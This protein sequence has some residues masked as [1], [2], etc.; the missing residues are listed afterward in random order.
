MNNI[1]NIIELANQSLEDTDSLLSECENKEFTKYY[2]KVIKLLSSDPETIINIPNYY[3]FLLSL[4]VTNTDNRSLF[5]NYVEDLD[6]LKPIVN[7]WEY[8][9]HAK[10]LLELYNHTSSEGNLEN[11]KYLDNFNNLNLSVLSLNYNLKIVYY[12]MYNFLQL[13]DNLKKAID[14]PDEIS[15]IISTKGKKIIQANRQKQLTSIFN[16]SGFKVFLDIIKNEVEKQ[17]TELKERRSILDKRKKYTLEVIKKEN[18]LSTLMN[19]PDNWHRY[20]DPRLLEELYYL[21]QSHIE[22]QYQDIITEEET[23]LQKRN[24]STLTTFLF[25][26][27]YNPYSLDNG[28]LT[29]LEKKPDLISS[30]NVLLECDLS[31]EEIF[32]DYI[33]ILMTLTPDKIT[34][35]KDLISKKALTLSTLKKKAL[36]IYGSKYSEI[37]TN[38]S[39]LEPIIE[40]ENIFYDDQILFESP[41]K[42]KNILQVLAN[43]HLTK[44]NYIYLLCH[45]TYLPIY[46]LLLE[47]NISVSLFIS[48]CETENPLN[49]I[50]RIIIYR[51]IHEQYENNNHRL[52]RDVAS[53][54]R[55]I[56]SDQELDE[57]IPNIV[58]LVSSPIESTGAILSTD[59]HHP[60][61]ELLDKD[62]G[63][64]DTYIIGNAIISR[65]KFIRNFSSTKKDSSSIIP[66]L[67]QS[68]ILEASQYYSLCD[69]LNNRVL[70]K[71]R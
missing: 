22:R 11:Y 7:S 52:K 9:P 61:V 40:F 62:F 43:Y 13:K 27:G 31:I 59:V 29:E 65:P 5:H 33:D 30:I 19:V 1:K 39:I 15:P 56:C 26:K 48:I 66:S 63:I 8:T 16:N 53:E 64:E 58:P 12:V 69:E 70:H 37:L 60:I 47:N 49:T 45:F 44:N 4:F 51:N 2:N 3:I 38:V 67:I 24:R 42:I 55:F 71:I 54:D 32:N 14:K 6:E 23:L 68:S 28:L 21:I 10:D 41:T 25:N 20:L 18:E 17:N 57:Y 34:S 35:I 46:D 36:N 50:K